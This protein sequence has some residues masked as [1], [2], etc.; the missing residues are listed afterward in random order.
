MN[1]TYRQGI[2]ALGLGAALLAAPAAHA[3]TLKVTVTNLGSA[4]GLTITPL[5]AAFHNGSY[6]SFSVGDTASAG[7]ELIAEQGDTSGVAGEL[8]LAQG[9]AVSGTIAAAGN[10]IPPIEPGESTSATFTVNG[11]DHA[12]FSYLSMILPS[13][14]QF[15]GNGGPTD[16]AIFDGSGTYLGNQTI[17]VYGTNAYDAGTEQNNGDGAPFVPSLAGTTGTDEGGTVHAA[18]GID[19]FAGLTVANGQVIDLSQINFAGNAN[20]QIA[21]IQIEAVPVPAALPLMLGGLGL[22]GFAARR[23]G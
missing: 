23:R 4:G 22:L 10:G 3:A 2:I 14:D 18:T 12:Y 21:T 16:H 9:S 19:N 11:T 17:T 1:R 13:N 8:A 6:D 15:I 20:Y 7:L 5:F